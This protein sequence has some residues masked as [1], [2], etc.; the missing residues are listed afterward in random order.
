MNISVVDTGKSPM[1]L[2]SFVKSFSQVLLV[3]AL[4]RLVKLWK[5]EKF[6]QHQFKKRSTLQV[7]SRTFGISQ[8]FL[9]L[10]LRRGHQFWFHNDNAR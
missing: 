9:T 8:P 7:R 2:G 5:K 6:G 3:A 10:N 4:H 1:T